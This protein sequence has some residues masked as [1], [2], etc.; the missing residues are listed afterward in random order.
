MTHAS[1]PQMHVVEGID[2]L[3]SSHGRLF[4]VVGVFDGLHRGHAYLLEHL[5]AEAGR[6]EARPAVITFDHHPDEILTG[7]SPPLL[8]DPNERLERLEQ[9][10]V[11]IT[12]IEVFDVALRM[13]PFDR[14][15]RRIAERVDL[16]GFLM[17]P[18]S[19]FGHDRGGTPETVA[20]LGRELGY[21]VAV[22]PALEIDGRA[23]RSAEIRA[24][25]AAGNLRDAGRL[26][27][28]PY[29]I[30]GRTEADDDGDWVVRVPMPVALPPAGDYEVSIDAAD[31]AWSPGIAPP[32]ADRTVPPTAF[33]GA[34]SIDETA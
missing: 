20:A 14:F 12:V 30:V 33:R 10:G 6:R 13:T 3:A 23:V 17:T 31:E 28:H 1:L 34:V 2:R 8:L 9:A 24:A 7:T 15:V 25:I 21:D 29:A 22:I 5:R 19:A 4:V 16:A 27:G 32:S 26:L 11:A 18:D